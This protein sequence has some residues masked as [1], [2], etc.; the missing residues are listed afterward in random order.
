MTLLIA[1]RIAELLLLITLT[2]LLA[3]LVGLIGADIRRRRQK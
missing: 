3:V 1:S 2:T